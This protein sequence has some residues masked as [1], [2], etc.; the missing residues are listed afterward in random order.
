MTAINF[1]E[2]GHIAD[3]WI[4]M[5]KSILAPG[6]ATDCSSLCLEACFR[7]G[8]C[9]DDLATFLSLPISNP[10]D[11]VLASCSFSVGKV[12]L[13]WHLESCQRGWNR[14]SA[15]SSA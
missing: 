15:C 10:S 4:M 14:I 7:T 9:P 11:G 13:D 1:R 3:A 8:F 12:K 5:H 6:N 2:L